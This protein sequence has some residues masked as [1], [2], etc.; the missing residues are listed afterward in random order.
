MEV[1]VYK[2]EEGVSVITPA[3][4]IS[5]DEVICLTV[6][7]GTRYAVLDD[8]T[9]PDCYFRDA[10]VIDDNFIITIDVK[11]AKD[12]QRNYW[13]HARLQRL[14][15]L[16]YQFMLALEEGNEE[17]II[18]IK[19]NKQ[20]LRDVTKIYLPEEIEDIKNVWPNVLNDDSGD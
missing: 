17:K 18:N 19:Q 1:I 7:E 16:D 12:I 10:W 14:Q 15:K 2:S 6:P 3:D 11:K 4:N 5:L 13:R 20:A 9:L 8:K